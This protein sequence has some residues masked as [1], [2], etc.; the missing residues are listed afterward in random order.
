MA[1][2]RG[3][4]YTL[5]L[6]AGLLLTVVSP[7]ASAQESEKAKKETPQG[8]P[9]LWR[10]PGDVAAKNMLLGPGGEE[11]KPDLSSVTFM[12]EETG[13]YS[14]KFRVKDGAG[15]IW[16]AKVGK[17]SQPET[18]S[19]RLVWAVGYV[20][21]IPY[22]VPCVHIKGA[23]ETKKKVDRCEGKGYANVRFEARPENVKRLDEWGWTNNPFAG[24]KEFK[25][26]IVLMAL[27]N[28]WDLKDANNKVLLV[29]GGES[30]QNELHYIISDLGATLGKTG[31]FITHNRNSPKDFAKSKFIEKVE[32]QKVV[33]AYDGKNK[34]L[35]ENITVAEAKWI[36]ELLAK[37]TDEQIADAVRA[38]N[39][40]PED[41]RILTTEIR[42]RI[43]ELTALPGGAAT[44]QR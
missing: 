3:V 43:K 13:G 20:T 9:V 40:S 36:G 34:G 14:P 2:K 26:L 32:G 29:P 31:N 24:A 5:V 28:N 15:K 39:Y 18:V 7:A 6:I 22:L 8:T 27:I 42:D 1:L 16:V 37:L 19:S 38:A 44:A 17:E 23:P 41:A 12:E 25:G 33:F 11:M 30:G 10:D 21:E 35:M 4:R